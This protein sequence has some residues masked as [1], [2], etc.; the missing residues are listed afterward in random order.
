LQ[1]LDRA[2][3]AARF[4]A[5]SDRYVDGYYNPQGGWAESGAVMTQLVAWAQAEG[6]LL[7]AGVAQEIV[8]GDDGVRGVRIDGAV[9]EARNVVVAAG[10]WT[11]TLLPWLAPVMRAVGQPVLHFAPSDADAFRPP[12]FVPW[13][14]DIARTGWYGFCANAD[15]IVKVANH[16][17]G[18]VVDPRGP[19]LVADDVE[20]MFRTFMRAALPSL[21]DA[22]R[23]GSRLCLYCDSFDGDLWIDADPQRRGLVVAAGGSGHGF[24]FA[25]LLG[26]LIA[27]VVE[28]GAPLNRFRWRAPGEQGSAATGF[29]ATGFEDARFSG[30]S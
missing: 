19:R 22:P 27:D 24:K 30:T 18:R 12:S 9:L 5:W 6:V 25:P 29:V 3:I 15:G 28:G 21:A 4:P 8:V 26:P 14:A 16:G 7:R 20:A 13:A 10:A 17:P 2:A 11:P 23:V 1:R